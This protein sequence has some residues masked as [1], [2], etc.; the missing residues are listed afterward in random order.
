MTVPHYPSGAGEQPAP[1]GPAPQEVET[2]F[3]CW[4]TIVVLSVIGGVLN[5]ALSGPLAAQI[6]KQQPALS[7]TSAE[8]AASAALVIG[9]VIAVVFIVLYVLFAFKMRA[10]RNWAR[11]TLTVLG[12]ISV[13]LTLIGIGT[14]L[15]LFSAGV[16]GILGGL[17]SFVQVLLILAAIYFMFRPASNAYFS[18]PAYR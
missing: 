17:L 5:F 16:V 2:A 7:R 18:A 15:A 4:L 8:A 14:I 12:G 10:G 1:A 6:A 13:L 11:I 3:K 9:L